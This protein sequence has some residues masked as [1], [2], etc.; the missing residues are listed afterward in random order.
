M[1]PQPDS[2]TVDRLAKVAARLGSDFA[3]EQ[4][5][6]AT[7]GTG[8]LASFGLTWQELVQRAFQVPVP[9]RATA[10]SPAAPARGTHAAT[11]LWAL[12]FRDLLTDR[13]AAFLA[14]I[15]RRRSLTPRQ[16]SW[17]NDITAKLHAR[18]AA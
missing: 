10:S 6:A 17:L 1:P 9:T 16:T 18:G 2:A 7:L 15:A 14:D 11:A 13:E 12:G 4:A 5:A 8:I 3:G